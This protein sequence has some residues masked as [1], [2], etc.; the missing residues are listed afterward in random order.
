MADDDV[1]CSSSLNI[2]SVTGA[3]TSTANGR[4]TDDPYSHYIDIDRLHHHRQQQPGDSLHHRIIVA[5][6]FDYR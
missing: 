5:R 4:G 3:R 6:R 1:K 2:F